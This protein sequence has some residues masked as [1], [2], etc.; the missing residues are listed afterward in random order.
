MILLTRRCTSLLRRQVRSLHAASPLDLSS[1]HALVTGASSGIGLAIAERLAAYSVRCTLVSRRAQKLESILASEPFTRSPAPAS[2]THNS[3]AGDVGDRHFWESLKQMEG[4]KGVNV[5]I[6]AAGV[7]HA[8]L[9]L[10]T[11]SETIEEVV[12]TNLM[13][14]IWGTKWAAKHMIQNKRKKK[15][16]CIVNVA[17]LLGVSGGKGSAAYAASKAG[18]I[19]MIHIIKRILWLLI[20][21]AFTRAMAAELGSSGVRVNAIVPGY[22][23]TN[24]TSGTIGSHYF[25]FLYLIHL[26]SS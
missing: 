16:L 9:L 5:L 15:D 13:G 8:S 21:K 25:N 18:V 17:S 14:T 12:Q 26:C 23:E 1:T 22:I 2:G 10:R 3:V 11:S 7:T 4:V 19:G 20:R 24:M 6:N